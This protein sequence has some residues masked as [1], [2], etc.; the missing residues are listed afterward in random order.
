MCDVVEVVAWNTAIAPAHEGVS[1]LGTNQNRYF[2]ITQTVERGK[3]NRRR[4]TLGESLPQTAERTR[5]LKEDQPAP[6]FPLL[7]WCRG[8][9]LGKPGK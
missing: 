1:A 3:E 2:W 8:V 9:P 5:P 6:Y 4:K 7:K